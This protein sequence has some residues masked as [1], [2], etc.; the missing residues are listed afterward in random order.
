M[1]LV[2]AAPTRRILSAQ[3]KIS[4][5]GDALA[6]QQHYPRQKSGMQAVGHRDFANRTIAIGWGQ[7]AGAESEDDELGVPQSFTCGHR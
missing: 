6:V 4:C 2:A 1:I 5:A 3:R 7:S